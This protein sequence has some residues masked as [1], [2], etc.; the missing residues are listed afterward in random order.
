MGEWVVAIVPEEAAGP[1]RGDFAKN[2]SGLVVL[3]TDGS[4]DGRHELSR[5]AFKRENSNN[6][7]VDFVDMLVG[8]MERAAVAVDVLNETEDSF[9][10]IEAKRVAAA[11]ARIKEILGAPRRSGAK[12]V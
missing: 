11:R 6:P 3:V 4:E 2:Y 8:E 9:A 1:A 7:G 5:V 12:P 10:R